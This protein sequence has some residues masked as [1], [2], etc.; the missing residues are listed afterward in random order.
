MW[1]KYQNDIRGQSLVEL[2][3]AMGVFVLVISSIMFVVLDAHIANQQGA[4]RSDAV[5]YAQSGLEAVRS[6]ANRQWGAAVPGTHGLDRSSGLWEL[7]GAYDSQTP[8]TR[9]VTIAYAARDSAGDLADTGTIDYDTKKVTAEVIWD[10]RPGRPGAVTLTEYLTH[11]NSVQWLQTSEQDFIQGTLDQ[12]AVTD[13]EGGALTLETIPVP[14]YGEWGYDIGEEYTYD[15]Q[16]IEV[17]SSTARLR[18]QAV[19]AEGASRN[20]DFTSGSEP[21]QYGDWDQDAGEVDMTGQWNSSGGNPD[22]AVDINVPGSFFRSMELGGWW[23]QPLTVTTDDISEAL[24]TLDWRMSRWTGSNPSSLHLYC[25]IDTVAGA[26][27]QGTEVWRSPLQTGATSWSHERFDVSDRLQSSGTYYI[28]FALWVEK[29]GGFRFEGPYTALFDNVELSW[30]KF[31]DKYPGDSPDIIT[32]NSFTATD[33]ASW[34]GFQEIADKDGGEIY[35]Q[36]SD[37]DGATWQYWDGSSWGVASN[38]AQVTVAADINTRIAALD[39]LAGQLAVRAFLASDGTQAVRLDHVRVTYEASQTNSWSFDTAS[40]YAFDSGLIQVVGSRA[41]LR[42]QGGGIYPS[43]QPAIAPKESLAP[44]VVSGWHGFQEIADKDGGEIYYQLSDD[45][46]ATWQYWDGSSWGVVRNQEDYSTAADVDAHIASIA[47]DSGQILWKAFLDSDGTQR[48]SLDD[49]SITY[50]IG[51]GTGHYTSGTYISPAHNTGVTAPLYNYIAWR[52]DLPA[53][54]QVTFQIRTA[55]TQDGLA[56]ATWVGP[57]GTAATS[58]TSS[59]TAITTA[60]GASGAQWIQYRA[61]LT[62]NNIS[63]PLINDVTI[64][65]EI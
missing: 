64:D 54:T 18:S 38:P 53:Q 34:H 45:D 49:V 43:N 57:D 11:W 9:Q 28:K 15:T 47:A 46:G 24:V 3:V 12:V 48:V 1:N 5:Y 7:A 59:G 35:Y 50:R 51:G 33:I 41:Q 44:G 20:T 27:V 21:W 58:Y 30:Q 63:A 8:F 29:Q 56:A 39:P 37:D 16:K 14:T 6:I 36:L 25:F 40:D 17:Q 19:L 26:P 22:G 23:E 32:N 62:T 10:F 13:H 2:L 52:A 55:S 60:P 31:G 4:E 61:T 65:Y 42:D